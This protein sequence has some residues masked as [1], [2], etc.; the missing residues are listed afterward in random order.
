MDP[1]HD[2]RPAP[3]EKPLATDC[4]GSG[5]AVCV[6]DAFDEEWRDYEAR[7]AAW[8]LRHPAADA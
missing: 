3:P 1:P 8:Q 5:C 4:C 7:L 6:F 2:P